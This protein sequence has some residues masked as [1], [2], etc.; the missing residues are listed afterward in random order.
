MRARLHRT[1]AGVRFPR[2]VAA[3]QLYDRRADALR[4]SAIPPSQGTSDLCVPSCRVAVCARPPRQW[5]GRKRRL[6]TPALRRAA[7]LP[8]GQCRLH[9][10]VSRG[11]PT[12]VSAAATSTSIPQ[13]KAKIAKLKSEVVAGPKGGAAKVRP[14]GGRAGIAPIL[15]PRRVPPLNSP[16]PPLFCHATFCRA[17]TASTSRRAATCGLGWRVGGGGCVEEGGGAAAAAGLVRR[18]ATRCV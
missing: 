10:V 9:H 6:R 8:A 15:R 4:P 14:R 11:R 12:R 5:K 18:R 1:R 13:L 3:H 16:H 7:V 2:E 17:G